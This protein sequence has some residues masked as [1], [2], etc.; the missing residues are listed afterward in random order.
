VSASGQRFAG[1]EWAGH[2]QKRPRF[3]GPGRHGPTQTVLPSRDPR[4]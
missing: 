2:E 3:H 1:W 4:G